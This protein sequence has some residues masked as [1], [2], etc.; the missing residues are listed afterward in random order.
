[1]T[2]FLRCLCLLTVL[3]AGTAIG[4]GAD[5]LPQSL[6]IALKPEKNPD[7]MLAEREAFS[8]SLSKILG[9]PV[10]V[11]VPLAAEEVVVPQRTGEVSAPEVE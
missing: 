2:M 6:V 8:S 11:I 4:R 7:A 9:R 1:M 5:S 3:V 10:Q